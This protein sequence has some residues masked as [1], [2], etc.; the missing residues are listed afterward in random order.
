MHEEKLKT[1]DRMAE[2]QRSFKSRKDSVPKSQKH[3]SPNFYDGNRDSDEDSHDVNQA[4]MP[5][6]SPGGRWY[7]PPA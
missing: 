5:S 2:T 4:T 3:C 1:V 7:N 6:Q